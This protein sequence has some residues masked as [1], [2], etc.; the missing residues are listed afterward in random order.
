MPE[1][2]CEVCGRLV[3]TLATPTGSAEYVLTF[4]N[5]CP[6]CGMTLAKALNGIIELLREAHGENSQRV[7]AK[8]MDRLDAQGFDVGRIKRRTA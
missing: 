7:L 3:S 4:Y 8:L 6:T 5:V 2:R 1:T